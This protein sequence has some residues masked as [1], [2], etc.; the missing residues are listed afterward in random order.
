M[1]M[2]FS[3]S[4]VFFLCSLQKH[5][6]CGTHNVGGE[7]SYFYTSVVS[8]EP[9]ACWFRALHAK[10]NI[11]N[12]NVGIMQKSTLN[13]ALKIIELVIKYWVWNFYS[14]WPKKML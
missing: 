10:I 4:E 5:L 6:D 9:I 8:R 13:K 1:L 12:L 7:E 2:V 3:W 14:N 11:I